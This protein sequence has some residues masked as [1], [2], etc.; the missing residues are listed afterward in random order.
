M[1]TPKAGGVWNRLYAKYLLDW[2]DR[3]EPQPL[4]VAEEAIRD[5][6]RYWAGE[7]QINLQP[8]IKALWELTEELGGSCNV[9]NR[10]IL[11]CRL[12]IY[13]VTEDT[14]DLWERD[15]AGVFEDFLRWYGVPID[16]IR[17]HK[18]P[19]DSISE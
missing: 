7:R 1:G 6:K 10:E 8:H 15:D 18:P 17:H 13:A 12:V 19:H 9:E 4:P 16:T 11:Y 5:T 2:I 3:I 14:D